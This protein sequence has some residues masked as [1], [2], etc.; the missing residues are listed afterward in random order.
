MSDGPKS[1]GRGPAF[2][3]APTV[4]GGNAPDRGAALPEELVRAVAKRSTHKLPEQIGG[5]RILER[6][7]VG[8]MAEVFLAEQQGPAG[9]KKRVV[10]KRV[11]PHFTFDPRF[12]ELFLREARIAARLSHPNVVQ[13][14][15]L[16]SADDE[17]FIVME[18]IDG[19]SLH[20]LARTAW[21]AGKSLPMELVVGAIAD[22]A[23]GLHHAHEL[24]DEAGQPV[25]LVHRDISPDNLMIS[26]DGVTKVLDFGIAKGN[27]GTNLTRTGELKGKVP[28]MPPEQLQGGDVDRRAD[29]YA[30]GV[31]LYW[32]LTGARP[33]DGD[34]DYVI[35][36]RVLRSEPEPPR[37]KNP[38]I[39]VQLE[40]IILSLLS[41]ERERR[42][43]TGAMLADALAN[44][45]PAGS[46]ITVDFVREIVELRAQG[47]ASTEPSRTDVL[48]STPISGLFGARGSESGAATPAPFAS[49]AGL[50][51]A[52]RRAG[53]GRAVAVGGLAA[54]VVTGALVWAMGAG[55]KEGVL[56]GPV[57]L[58]EPRPA[59]SAK[60]AEPASA[61]P[62]PAEPKPAEPKPTEPKPAGEAPLEAPPTE[63]LEEKKPAE[64]ER[65]RR[66]RRPRAPRTRSL[67]V[68]APPHIEWRTLSGKLL[69]KGSGTLDVPAGTS[70][71]VIVDPRRGGRTRVPIRG[72]RIEY[73]KLPKGTLDV[74]VFPFAEVFLGGERIG[75]TPVPP[76]RV[77]AGHYT[78][79]LRHEGKTRRV[80]VDVG[81]GQVKRVKVNLNET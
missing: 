50:E 63:P 2:S 25:N 69:G 38:S 80:E 56:G 36:D 44:L 6:L 65:P 34:S 13:I 64:A 37:A 42:I 16:G 22:A 26:R 45:L 14:Y 17:Y 9:F 71:L 1:D 18:H 46:Q 67:P 23:R 41:K 77:V 30:L 48:A 8:G 4:V 62:A 68:R 40:A 60:P 51:V 66:A 15:E 73:E 72:R 61:E 79:K 52:P 32:L 5:Y 7:G 3:D 76:I 53:W 54:L 74:R 57:A 24:L 27:E 12:V 10:V 49:D 55:R 47:L 29:L 39:P 81:A 35:L 20:E 11:L 28:Y 33:F 70:T 43:P 75:S 19:M 21:A 31:S 58:L 78:L 59:E